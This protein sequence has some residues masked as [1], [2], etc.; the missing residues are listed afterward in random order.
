LVAAHTTSRCGWCSRPTRSLADEQC[1][2]DKRPVVV[3]MGHGP[4]RASVH[5]G[6][7]VD[8]CG[9]F[10]QSDADRDPPP[11][12]DLR[13]LAKP[14][15]P[16]LASAAC[17]R[18]MSSEHEHSTPRV[19]RRPNRLDAGVDE[20]FQDGRDQRPLSRVKIPPA[21]LQPSYLR[22]SRVFASELA[23]SMGCASQSGKLRRARHETGDI[24]YV[25][26]EERI[27]VFD[28][29]GTLCSERTYPFPVAFALDQVQAMAPQE[30]FKSVLAGDLKGILS[31][32][33]HALIAVVAA[34]NYGNLS[35]SEKPNWNHR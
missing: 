31:G 9:G 17:C 10:L 34:T 33:Y 12:T 1:S 6:W 2:F 35:A 32:G 26:P 21:N 7:R 24:D 19:R 4:S 5:H 14:A 11:L 20:L 25:A 30:L 29:D 28:D 13:F 16:T 8:V 27:A 18:P 23:D 3:G 22:E 15:V